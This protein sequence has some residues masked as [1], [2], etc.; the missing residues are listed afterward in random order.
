V[1][2]AA[3]NL[4][5][6]S[7][8]F[9]NAS[10][11]KSNLTA[12][13]TATGPDNVAN[14]ASTLTATAGNATALQA[15]TS[16]SSS[17][18]TSVYIKRRT[19]SGNI[20]LTQDNGS[21]WT[22]Q[23]V[24]SSWTRVSL[25]AVTSTNPTVGIRIV[26][27]GDEVDVWCLQ[28]ETGTVVTSPIITYA[29]A[30]TRA[31]DNIAIATTLFPLSTTAETL[32]SGFTLLSTGITDIAKLKPTSGIAEIFGFY[33]TPSSIIPIV[34]NGGSVSFAEGS[35]LSP[36]VGAHKYAMA[37]EVNNARGAVDGTLSIADTTSVT[38]PGTVNLLT[39]GSG[40]GSYGGSSPFLL[41]VLAYFP[42]RKADATLQ[43]MTTA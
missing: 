17:R 42:E 4:C 22:T 41:S 30:V 7:N 34:R 39:L 33:F 3:T 5:L 37:A 12:A 18:V 32:Y 10:W 28:H 36:V 13:L 26:T 2:P 11:T 40:N 8:D 38:M 29:A 15:I 1:E 19:G 21:T 24:T 16:A 35:Y 25:A 27:S 23:T 9:T 43:T 14:S 31:A 20:D 6:R